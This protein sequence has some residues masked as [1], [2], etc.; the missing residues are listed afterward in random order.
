MKASPIEQKELLRLQALD[1]RLQ[2]VD[3]QTRALA[4]HAELTA[5]AGT[6]DKT[7]MNL[8]TLHG[9]VED[10]R[11]ELNRIESDVEVVEKR[12]KRD[13]ERLQTTSSVKDV[14][15]LDTE[16][17][18]LRKRLLAL[19][20]IEIAVMERLEER[21]SA[22]AVV[23]AERDALAARVEETETSRDADLATLHR[24]LEE[25]RRD[26]AVIAGT[27]APDLASLYEK[28]FVSGHGNAAALLRQRTCSGCTITLTGSDLESVRSSA[29]DEVLF[30]PDCGAILVRTEE[31][32]I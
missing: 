12:I 4:Q 26:R 29:A 5:L 17:A 27:I 15:A 21:E 25:L 19:E 3:H 13:D 14:Q 16:L 10:V 11:L 6:A 32:G 8:T 7:R 18:A 2:Q 30:C 28:L 23:E 9:E 31:S 22:V 1:I 20:E 24:Q